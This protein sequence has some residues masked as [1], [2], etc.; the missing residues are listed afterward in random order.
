M[1][2]RISFKICGIPTSASSNPAATNYKT[3][4]VKTRTFK[5]IRDVLAPLLHPYNLELAINPVEESAR[6][7]GGGCAI[8]VNVATEDGAWV[9]L[10][11]DVSTIENKRL[12]V[13]P[14]NGGDGRNISVF[15]CGDDM[16]DRDNNGPTPSAEISLY[17]GLQIMRRGRFEDQRGT[18]IRFEIPDFLKLPESSDSSRQIS[19]NSTLP[20][21]NTSTP[22]QSFTAAKVNKDSIQMTPIKKEVFNDSS[23][24]LGF[25]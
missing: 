3:L 11:R 20:P 1:E 9:D 4:N 16:T 2:Q 10:N 19:S 14:C 17:E 23:P 22:Q 18:E 7:G 15:S 13:Q 24:T 6:N 21:V 5:Q 8:A 12:F 25:V